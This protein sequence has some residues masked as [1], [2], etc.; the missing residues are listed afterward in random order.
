MTHTCPKYSAIKLF[1]LI[2]AC[3]SRFF[4]KNL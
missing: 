4:Q 3:Q 2:Q 1:D